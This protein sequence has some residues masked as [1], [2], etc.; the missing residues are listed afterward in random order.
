MNKLEPQLKQIIDELPT[1]SAEQLQALAM[2]LG[3]DVE[4][5]KA[6]LTKSIIAKIEQHSNADMLA[7][8]WQLL[9]SKLGGSL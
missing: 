7:N 9:K 3:V 1:L 6:A 4:Q 5:H 2:L 8:M